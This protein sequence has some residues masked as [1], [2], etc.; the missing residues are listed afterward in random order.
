VPPVVDRFDNMTVLW[1]LK[2]GFCDAV[3]H[4]LVLFRKATSVIT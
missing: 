1:Q 3:Q 2:S 4:A